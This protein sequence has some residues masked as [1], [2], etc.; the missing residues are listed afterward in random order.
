MAH[1][2]V[3]DDD[4]SQR[5]TMR[6]ILQRAGYEIT[7]AADGLEALNVVGSRPFALA[8]VDLYMSRMDGL[9]AIPKLVFQVP[10]LKV[11]AM[12]GGVLGGKGTDLLRVAE[13]LGAVR[14]LQKPFGARELVELVA[15]LLGPSEDA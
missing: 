13:D 12:S 2:L 8:F 10:D 11:V 7:L 15:E 6:R 4:A 9:E 1:I 5:E 14:A 3:V